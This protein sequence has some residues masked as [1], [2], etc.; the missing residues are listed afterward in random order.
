MIM[1]SHHLVMGLAPDREHKDKYEES[2]MI[3]LLGWP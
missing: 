2:H 1:A 3:D